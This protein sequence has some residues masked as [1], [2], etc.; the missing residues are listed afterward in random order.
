MA[1]PPKGFVDLHKLPED[2]RIRIIGEHVMNTGQTVG[3]PTDSEPGKA[4]LYARKLR[5]QF[6]GI[7][8]E[9][10]FDGPTPGCRTI[11]VI[12]PN[13]RNN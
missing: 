13:A 12:P 8:V 6:P 3:V 5:E 10:P 1:G 4:E 2:E 9:G 7:I 11:R